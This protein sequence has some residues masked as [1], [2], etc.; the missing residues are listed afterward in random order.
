ME[1]VV[2]TGMGAVTPV[3]QDLPSMWGSLVAGRS[4]AGP[5]TLFDSTAFAVH[6]ACEVKN[7]EPARFIEKKKLK[8]LD[9]FS[10]FAMASAR[11]AI[12]DAGLVLTEEEQPEAGCIIGV[13]IGGLARIEACKDLLNTKGPT[14]I[15]PY[16]IP[17]IIANM[18]AGQISMAHGLKGPS[19]C[20]TSACSSGAHAIGEAAGWIR[21]GMTSVMVVGGAESSITPIGMGGFQAMFALSRRNDAP[22]KASRPFDKGRDGFVSGEGAGVLV[23]ESLSRAQAR[24]AHIY[25]ELTGY[26][27]S[28][29]AHHITHPAPEGEGAQRS[30][31]M[32]LRDARLNPSDI[33][34][35]NAHGTST[36]V[37]DKEECMAIKRVMGDHTRSG[38]L[39]MSSTK[40]MM[41]H[42]LGAAGA[43]EAII[44]IMALNK[45]I[46]PP[47]INVDEQD[48]DCDLDV[49]P[50]TPRERRVQHVMSNAFGFGGA[51]TTLVFSALSK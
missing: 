23:L 24:G 35:I 43:V 40:S 27:A 45:G 12:E 9:R 14:R 13:G 20:T 41:G 7:W 2:V 8:E 25:A 6:F 16:T 4:G 10:E 47:T 29:D 31:R 5:I 32:A 46:L 39:S 37:G 11:M 48:P 19:Y 51:N 22:D 42:L 26:G 33:G 38:Q 44:S 3:G 18:A 21:R 1:R 30:M 15:S 34:Y 17:S 28:S 49:V 50:N 36:P